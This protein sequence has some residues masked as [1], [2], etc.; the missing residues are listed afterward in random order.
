MLSLMGLSLA[1]KWP[2]QDARGQDGRWFLATALGGK[3]T[4]IGVY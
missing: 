3:L 4:V 2:R 1:Q